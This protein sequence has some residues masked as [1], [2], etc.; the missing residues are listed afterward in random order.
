MVGR[1]AYIPSDDDVETIRSMA[2]AG[3]T[4]VV[5]AEAIGIS[6]PTLQKNFGALMREARSVQQAPQLPLGEGVAQPP[7]RPPAA[8]RRKA[9]RK[10]YEPT[11]EDKRRVALLLADN[12]R[13]DLIA[14]LIGV[15]L[16]TFEAAFEEEIELS[17]LR[18][19]AENL[20]RLESAAKAGKVAAMK[21]LQDRLDNAV[22]A[23]STAAA[24][25]PKA[26]SP[27]DDTPGKKA[28]AHRRAVDIM[29]TGTLGDLTRPLRPTRPN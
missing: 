9:G 29:A 21:H 28:A 20:E 14:K 15:S 24:P 23:R 12:Q 26:Q 6:V 5:M 11:R 25:S 4:R 22:G 7:T 2:A 19:T 10:R 13:K 18:L 1:K 27:K 8:E 3:A 17:A 16:P